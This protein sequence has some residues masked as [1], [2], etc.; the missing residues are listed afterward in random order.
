MTSVV[1]LTGVLRKPDIW[2][3]GFALGAAFIIPT[4]L[5]GMN[6]YIFLAPS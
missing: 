2:N 3:L 5:S 4:V 1:L 6:T